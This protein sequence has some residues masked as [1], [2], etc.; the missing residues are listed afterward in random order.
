[1]PAHP[2]LASP[3][4]SRPRRWIAAIAFMVVAGSC[5]DG[6]SEADSPSSTPSSTSGATATSLLR[7]VA[8]PGQVI[9]AHRF[10]V[11]WWD[12]TRW[13]PADPNR[14]QPPDAEVPLVLGSR[15]TFVS[16]DGRRISRTLGTST[17]ECIGPGPVFVDVPDDVDDMVGVAD[18]LE[19]L[20]RPVVQIAAAPAHHESVRAWLKGEGVA[21]P[22]VSIDRVTRADL[23][24]D[25]V[26][27]VLIEAS[28][29]AEE[30]LL[31]RA[32]GDYSVVLM[33]RLKD[34]EVETV[35][36]R[37]DVVTEDEVNAEHFGGYLSAS[38]LLAIADV[39]GDTW[40]EV[41]VARRAYESSAVAVYAWDGREIDDV[42]VAGCGA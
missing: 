2:G 36:V 34:G 1:M 16:V 23:E 38:R 3:V 35:L 17:S 11:G 10:L 9:V 29:H 21:T 25:G 30:S 19:P 27:E 6:G 31:G 37:G 13:L 40:F 26:D 20:P 4:V 18:G 32:A 41:V 39:D 7:T 33:R 22:E 28:L 8:P 12:G 15:Y 24:G 14:R 42:L 5:T